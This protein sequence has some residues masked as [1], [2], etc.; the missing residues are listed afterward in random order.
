VTDV[1]QEPLVIVELHASNV[2]RL[3]AV[4]VRPDPDDHV[5]V[6]GG[7]NGSGKTSV[8]NAIALAL[9]GAAAAKGIPQPVRHGADDA[10]IVINLGRYIVTRRFDAHRKDASLTVTTP[11][12]AKFSSPQSFLN[13]FLGDFTFDPLAFM[14]LSAKDQL[15]TLLPLVDLPFDLDEIDAERVAHYEDRT[16]VGRERD[17]LKAQLEAVP[18]PDPDGPTE[19]VSTEALIVELREATT[20]AGHRAETQALAESALRDA[21][22]QEDRIAEIDAEI[23]RLQAARAD[24]VA[25]RDTSMRIATERDAEA[26]A[27][28]VPDVDDIQRRLADVE[29]T[30]AKVRDRAEHRR[31]WEAHQAKADEYDGLTLLIAEIDG[32]KRQA[33]ADAA[34][35][36]VGLSFDDRQVFLNDVP[37]VQCSAAEQ[38]RASM[39]IGMA[40]NPTIRVMCIADGSLLDDTSMALVSQFAEEH[41]AQLWIEVVGD[42]TPG[43]IIIEDGAVRPPADTEVPE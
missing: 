39:A 11:D 27:I 19:E 28:V 17:R 13:E 42:R 29:A 14:R 1:D 5:V 41:G 31:L 26:N 23:A 8:L 2:M 4:H 37:L 16:I 35:P 20:V 25:G 10:E 32:R 40:A 9:G 24:A 22:Y 21:R 15:A 43:A 36:I 3:S 30:N 34:M 38:L 7:Q 18:A 12:G 33:I 6:I